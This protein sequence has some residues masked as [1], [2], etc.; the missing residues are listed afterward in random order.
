ML[1]ACIAKV[2]HSKG[3]VVIRSKM[4]GTSSEENEKVDQLLELVRGFAV[5]TQLVENSQDAIYSCVWTKVG[6]RFHLDMSSM[7]TGKFICHKEVRDP[8]IY[9]YAFDPSSDDAM[10]TIESFDIPNG[11]LMIYDSDED[12]QM[13]AKDFWNLLIMLRASCEIRS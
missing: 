2:N 1:S 10:Q 11:H 13:F 6:L 9:L 3:V 4:Y 8:V 12:I 5:E 7:G